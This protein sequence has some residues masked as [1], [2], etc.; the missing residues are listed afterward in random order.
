MSD[1]VR[2]AV[3]TIRVATAGDLAYVLDR[4]KQFSNQVGFIPKHTTELYIQ[5]E[6]VWVAEIN[7]QPIGALIATGGERCPLVF[8]CN[9]VEKELW[10]QGWGRAFTD[11]LR[12]SP[13]SNRWGGVKVRTRRDLTAQY[14][15]NSEQ[16]G[17]VLSTTPPG[18]RGFP[19]DEWWLPFDVTSPI[20]VPPKNTLIHIIED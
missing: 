5:R 18:V 10:E 2:P 4:Q 19:V 16:G 7:G 12:Q 1:A 20:F 3:A 9:M 11:W 17:K 8:R 15:I 13:C 6:K 14:H